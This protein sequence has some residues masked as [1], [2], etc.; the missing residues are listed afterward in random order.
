MIAERVFAIF[1]ARYII[2]RTE[3]NMKRGLSYI[4]CVVML[5]SA[6]CCEVWAT[7]GPKIDSQPKDVT[8]AKNTTATFEVAAT[9]SGTLSYQ[10][11]YSLNNGSSWTNCTESTAKSAKFLTKVVVSCLVRCVVTD[12]NGSTPSNSAKLTMS[13]V[14]TTNK[15]GVLEY[16]STKDTFTATYNNDSVKTD[17]QYLVL[18]LKGTSTSFDKDFEDESVLYVNQIDGSQVKTGIDILPKANENSVVWLGG[19]FDNGPVLI[20]TV[21]VGG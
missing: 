3:F 15:A 6:L 11:Q 1:L 19:E 8:A 16:S 2:E 21:T 13:T 5:L 10:W 9:G 18:V 14:T 20:G 7:G 17:N 4:L 12:K